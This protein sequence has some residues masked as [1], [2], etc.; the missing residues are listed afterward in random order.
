MMTREDREKI[1]Q[2]VAS[3]NSKEHSYEENIQFAVD[4][5]RQFPFS[6][7]SIL[8]GKRFKKFWDDVVART[9]FLDKIYSSR[10]IS[11][12]HYYVNKLEKVIVCSADGCNEPYTKKIT[13]KELNKKR[14]YC[15][16]TCA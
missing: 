4:M 14:F 7:F 16:S 2:L 6:C 9:H 11:R 15:N 5:Q 10:D 3:Y 1:K 13:P 8:R 12:L